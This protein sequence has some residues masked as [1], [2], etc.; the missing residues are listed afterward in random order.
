MNKRARERGW[1]K[2]IARKTRIESAS[3]DVSWSCFFLLLLFIY[4]FYGVDIATKLVGD[5]SDCTKEWIGNATAD[6]RIVHEQEIMRVRRKGESRVVRMSLNPLSFLFLLYLCLW[7]LYR[8]A[9][10]RRKDVQLT[11]EFNFDRKYSLFFFWCLLLRFALWYGYRI[12]EI[13]LFLWPLYLRPTLN[14]RI[15]SSHPT[16]LMVKKKEKKI[17]FFFFWFPSHK[18]YTFKLD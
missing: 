6:Q 4:L 16:S 13:K 8:F 1:G 14:R 12:K 9:I 3:H 2:F 18:R 15:D 10:S 7:L 5:N 11:L 17:T